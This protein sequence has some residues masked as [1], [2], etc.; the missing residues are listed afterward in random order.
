MVTLMTMESREN[1]PAEHLPEAEGDLSAQDLYTIEMYFR[2]HGV[3]D[4]QYDAEL[5]GFRFPEDGRF[6][7]CEE[8]ADWK[9]L[10]ERGYLEF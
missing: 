5:D 3:S 4:F 9:R 10:E 1:K 6:A 8:F 7:F 2:N